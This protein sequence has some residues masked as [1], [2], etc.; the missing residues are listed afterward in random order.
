MKTTCLRGWRTRQEEMAQ[1]RPVVVERFKAA[2]VADLRCTGLGAV[3]P[4]GWTVSQGHASGANEML[5]G[6]G[7]A[8]WSR[9]GQKK[10]YDA[11]P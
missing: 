10:G 11:K 3:T 7:S 5:L 2:L 8:C 6:P 4:A 9:R 1:E